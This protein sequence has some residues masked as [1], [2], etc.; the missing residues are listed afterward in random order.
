MPNSLAHIGLTAVT[1]RPRWVLAILALGSFLHLLLDALQTKLA[2]EVHVFAPVSWDL[3]IFRLFWPEDVPTLAL[4]RFG[5]LPLL[6]D[7]SSYL[8]LA[9]VFLAWIRPLRSAPGMILR[10]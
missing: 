5:L 3:L 4:T 10:G 9:L 1:T 2:N 7:A 6:R 8:A